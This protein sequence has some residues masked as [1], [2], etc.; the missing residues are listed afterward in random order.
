MDNIFIERT[1][2]TPEVQMDKTGKVKM[3]GRSIPEDPAK[4]YE[5]LYLW[6]YEYCFNPL[7]KTIIDIDLEYFNSGSFKCLLFML[8]EFSELRNKGKEV[9]IN[10]VYEE[11]DD[12][13]RERGEYFESILETKINIIQKPATT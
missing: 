9:I 10:W 3:S 4:F 5:P 11:G 6:I 13:I 7:P 2:R 1:G 12:D 8:K